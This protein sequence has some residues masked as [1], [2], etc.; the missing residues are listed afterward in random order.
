MASDQ[1][2][3]AGAESALRGFN[4]EEEIT[5]VQLCYA[6][7]NFSYFSIA[8]NCAECGKFDDVVFTYK[9]T[10]SG[11]LKSILIQSKHQKKAGE[12]KFNWLMNDF[13]LIEHF[14]SYLEVAS[15]K[16]EK[17]GEKTFVI[18]TNRTFTKKFI[19]YKPK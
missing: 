3:T 4:Y 8:R 1:K 9:E 15:I 12:L 19:E 6:Y 13:D 10:D 14:K 5:N 18:F 16:P 17:Y 7:D 11:P 2:T